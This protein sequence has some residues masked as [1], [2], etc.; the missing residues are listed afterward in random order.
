MATLTLPEI[1]VMDEVIPDLRLLKYS[2]DA[3][4]Q[5]IGKRAVM[6][7]DAWGL[8][9]V[10]IDEGR[11]ADT[12]NELLDVAYQAEAAL[13]QAKQERDEIK[14]TLLAVQS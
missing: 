5:E 1:S 12:K 10:A 13:S 7:S 2:L 14:A 3:K 4:E 8:F 9:D 11:P 6:V